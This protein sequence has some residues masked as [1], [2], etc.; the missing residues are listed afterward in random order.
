M[1][2]E[3]SCAHIMVLDK[4][5]RDAVCIFCDHKQVVSREH[6]NVLGE[7][8]RAGAIVVRMSEK[9]R[10]DRQKAIRSLGKTKKRSKRRK[11]RAKVDREVIEAVPEGFVTPK[12]AVDAVDGKIDGKKIRRLAREGKIERMRQGRYVFVRLTDVERICGIRKKDD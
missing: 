2:D 12:D 7:V 11:K 8:E 4:N 9:D 10:K 5:E 1:S 6:L 3:N